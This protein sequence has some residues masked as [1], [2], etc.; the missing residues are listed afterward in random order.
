MMDEAPDEAPEEQEAFGEEAE[1]EEEMADEAGEEPGEEP[2]EGEEMDEP[3][4][5]VEEMPDEE[6]PP[7]VPEE[8]EELQEIDAEAAE[9]EAEAEAVEAEAE[10]EAVEGEEKPKQPPFWVRRAFWKV[11]EG[12]YFLRLRQKVRT[13][14]DAQIFCDELG[15][16]IEEAKEKGERMTFEDFDIAQTF[17]PS[18]HLETM[19][20][21]LSDGNVQIERLRAFGIPT[22]DDAG[23]VMLSGWLQGVVPETVPHE[24]H[25]SDCAITAVGF[26]AIMD[27]LNENQTFP[28][29]DPK[30]P[31]EGKL[32]LYLRIEGNYIETSVIQECL[33]EGTAQTM[34]KKASMEHSDTVK[35]RILIRGD[36]TEDNP[37]KQNEGDPPDPENAPPPKFVKEKG[38]GKGKH[39]KGKGKGKGKGSYSYRYWGGGAKNS[40]ESQPRQVQSKPRSAYSEWKPAR[41]VTYRQDSRT[42][43][44]RWAKPKESWQSHNKKWES[45][46]SNWSKPEAKWTKP[47]PKWSKQEPK[48][49]K[50]E[51][52]WSK[53]ETKWSSKTGNEKWNSKWEKNDAK[54]DSKQEKWSSNSKPK[55]EAWEGQKKQPERKSDWESKTWKDDS[56]KRWLHEETGKGKASKGSKTAG[57]AA[58]PKSAITE[59]ER[60]QR[61]GQGKGK[62]REEKGKAGRDSHSEPFTAFRAPTRGSAA[63]MTKTQKRETSAPVAAEAKRPRLAGG[64][65]SLPPGWE[66]HWSDQYATHYYWNEKTGESTWDVPK[67]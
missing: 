8:F 20:S 31:E 57:L 11:R 10:T 48:W 12:R 60:S 47:E 35:C 25:L 40:W 23:A 62:G 36:E 52:K 32:A 53:P 3:P 30:K 51:D 13:P 45:K 41:Q 28:A 16:R 6:E 26:R 24:L 42:Q 67:A 65:D 59:A 9:A 1:A 14:E 55:W 27:A 58:L 38:K 56:W 63:T 54:Q 39:S 49:S 66:K 4:E 34:T 33:D 50:A 46:D 37:F 64:R 2:A 19:F 43:T 15:R 61:F 18:E 7:A 22:L 29:D 44:D 5:D 17:I 21:L